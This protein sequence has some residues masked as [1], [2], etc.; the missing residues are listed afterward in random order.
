MLLSSRRFFQKT[1]KPIRFF[2]LTVLKQVWLLVFWKNLRTPK[3]P[4]EMT[5]REIQK[6]MDMGLKTKFCS[7]F[8]G[9]NPK[10][11]ELFQTKSERSS[12]IVLVLQKEKAQMSR[13][14]MH[15]KSYPAKQYQFF[16]IYNQKLLI[17]GLLNHIFLIQ[18]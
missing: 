3:I 16:T 7:I 13:F 12:K 17:L 1:N 9:H 10:Q 18:N 4:F 2:F 14:K 11:F 8:F 5:F 15:K 6:V